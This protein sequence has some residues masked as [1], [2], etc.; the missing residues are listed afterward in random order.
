MQIPATSSATAVYPAVGTSPTPRAGRTGLEG[1]TAS[2]KQLIQATTGYA[3]T[4]DTQLAPAIAFDIA[5]DRK[6]GILTGE[7][8]QTYLDGVM[9]RQ[10]GALADQLAATKDDAARAAQT[11]TAVHGS[12]ARWYTAATAFLAQRAAETGR[13]GAVLDV[14]A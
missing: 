14:Q 10:S 8:N 7:M 12:Y 1:L 3:I 9:A 2:D 11:A 13:P 6:V 5:A 4:D